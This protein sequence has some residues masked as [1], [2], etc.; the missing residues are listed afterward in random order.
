MLS[1]PRHLLLLHVLRKVIQDEELLDTLLTPG[2]LNSL[3]L[4]VLSSW[5][6]FEDGHNIFLFL[7]I[8]TSPDLHNPSK[9]IVSGLAMAAASSLNVL[10][11]SPSS[12][13][14][15]YGLSSCKSPL[16]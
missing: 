3:Q 12:P 4:P 8:G 7:V 5:T 13:A 9:M 16:T 15:L 2:R 14:D 10:P 11:C 6:F 1:V